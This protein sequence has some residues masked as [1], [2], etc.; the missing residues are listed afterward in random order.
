MQTNHLFGDTIYSYTR[1]QAI[2]DG[3]LVDATDMAQEAGIHLPVAV[4]QAVW[5]QYI[6]WSD[7]DTDLQ[8][9]QDETGR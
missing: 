4:S 2:E 1:A 3:V 6:E 5:D 8:V 7:Q 9:F